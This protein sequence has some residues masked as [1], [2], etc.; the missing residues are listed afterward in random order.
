[1][2]LWE[3]V[4]LVEAPKL[5]PQRSVVQ[6]GVVQAREAVPLGL[7]ALHILRDGVKLLLLF[8]SCMRLDASSWE[9]EGRIR[10]KL[11]DTIRG[12]MWAK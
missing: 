3:L 7:S 11:Q 2:L 5:G 1:M 10:Q 8:D 9:T 12:L 6:H 4:L